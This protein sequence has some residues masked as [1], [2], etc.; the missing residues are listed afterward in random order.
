MVLLIHFYI[1]DFKE[2]VYEEKCYCNHFVCSDTKK[3]F[4]FTVPDDELKILSEVCESFLTAHIEIAFPA[5][6]V[7]K[8]L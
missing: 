4:S 5:L 2:V 8:S 6:K 3:L 1:L 7:Y